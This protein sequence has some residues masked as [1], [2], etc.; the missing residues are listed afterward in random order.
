MPSPSEIPLPWPCSLHGAEHSTKE[1]WCLFSGLCIPSPT[2]TSKRDDVKGAAARWNWRTSTEGLPRGIVETSSDMFLRPLWDSTAKHTNTKGRA[3]NMCRQPLRVQLSP[4]EQ[5][6]VEETFKLYL[7]FQSYNCR[8]IH[9]I[10]PSVLIKATVTTRKEMS[11]LLLTGRR[12]GAGGSMGG[13]RRACR[14]CLASWTA[15]RRNPD[16]H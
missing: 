5:L 16:T 2:P 1:G 8:C 4:N 13:S 15:F 12:Q 9:L 14:W 3:D 7:M 10:I 6:A 11:G